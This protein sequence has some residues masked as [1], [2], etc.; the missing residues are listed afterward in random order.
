MENANEPN[1]SI[2]R[3]LFLFGDDTLWEVL[4]R[5]W[6]YLYGDKKTTNTNVGVTSLKICHWNNQQIWKWVDLEDEVDKGRSN[7]S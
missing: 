4:D 6:D 2:G 1:V 5:G 3:N 7:I